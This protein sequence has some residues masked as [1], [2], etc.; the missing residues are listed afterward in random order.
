[1]RPPDWFRAYPGWRKSLLLGLIILGG[2][3]T[4][5]VACA[6][7]KAEEYAVKAAYLF[8]FAKFVEWPPPA[9]PTPQSPLTL[10]ITGKD[11]F[12]DTLETVRDKSVRDRPLVIRRLSRLEEPTH[13]HLLFLSDSES[14]RLGQVLA[15]LKNG[16]ILTVSDIPGFAD[17]GGM[18][19]LVNVG[20]RIR[21][22]IN[23]PTVQKANLKISS[24]LLKLAKIIGDSGQY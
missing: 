24:Q 6:E 5:E 23:L 21:F 22:E 2:G 12:G 18:I 15:K 10:C 20:Q 8:N 13:C 17:A 11:P 9:L 4:P 1:M 7:D 3:L 16:P 14:T 19:G